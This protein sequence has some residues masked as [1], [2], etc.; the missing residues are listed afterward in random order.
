MVVD[1]IDHEAGAERCQAAAEGPRRVRG[2]TQE[3][4]RCVEGLHFGEEAHFIE[5]ARFSE[6]VSPVPILNTTSRFCRPE[7]LPRVWPASGPRLARVWPASALRLAD[8]CPSRLWLPSAPP[9]ETAG[10]C[11]LRPWSEGPN[12]CVAVLAGL[13]VVT[14]VLRKCHRRLR[15]HHLEGQV[16][17]KR[18]VDQVKAGGAGPGV[19]IH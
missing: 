19:H 17:V 10:R 13:M 7:S 11:L 12:P 6:T 14:V 3:C 16:N 8:V 2:R 5:E 4:R 18:H 15:V 1:Q 9:T